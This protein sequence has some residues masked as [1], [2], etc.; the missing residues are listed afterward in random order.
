M[1]DSNQSV[2]WRLNDLLKA[3]KK[4]KAFASASWS[5]PEQSGQS[6]GFSQWQPIVLNDLPD[7]ARE[8]E[9]LDIQA[10]TDAEEAEEIAEIVEPVIEEPVVPEPGIGEEE[11]DAAKRNSYAEG[12]RIGQ[13]EAQAQ[14]REAKEGFV[15]LTQALRAA[16]SDM[17]EF[18]APL[19]KL[20]LHL[21]EQLVRGEL[22]L[23]GAAIERLT[24][25]AL[26]DLEQ[27]GEGP[28]V[29]RLHPTDLEKFNRQ[30]D[31]ELEGID[32]RGDRELTQGSVKV[33][34]DDSAIEDL[35]DNRLNALSE[36]VLGYSYGAPS[37]ISS[38]FDSNFAN[39]VEEKVIEGAVLVD[40][41][42]F[43][44]NQEPSSE[45]QEPSSENQEPSSEEQQPLRQD[46]ELSDS[47]EQPENPDADP[48][49]PE[50]EAD[51]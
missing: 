49:N 25:E 37:A 51:V 1:S 9:S 30:L 45:N 36:T 32:L 20:A 34:I 8:T 50:P 43:S 46:N 5:Q 47:S 4:A 33:S 10:Q 26:K 38:N 14:L 21:A 18:Y 29:V 7:G 31:G 44:E 13:E 11:L 42:P 24:K 39:P 28:I 15:E 23:S 2:S 3:G 35:L 48:D 12:Y 17:T 40:D 22:T 27:Q 6:T 16:Q 41:E 19:K